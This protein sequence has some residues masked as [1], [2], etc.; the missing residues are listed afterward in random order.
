MEGMLRSRLQWFVCRTIQ[1]DDKI[2][3]KKEANKH[4]ILDVPVMCFYLQTCRLQAGHSEL[5]CR[6]R[7]KCWVK[8]SG[9][10]DQHSLTTK[11]KIQQE[12]PVTQW[13]ASERTKR[14]YH[15]EIKSGFSV[16]T[17]AACDLCCHVLSRKAENHR[18]TTAQC[19]TNADDIQQDNSSTIHRDI[20]KG[21]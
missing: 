14:I 21:S 16:S 5:H 19:L 18:A 1:S 20:K 9:C 4:V 2:S 3:S 13:N 11:G 8:F 12:L 7:G 10:V 15:C 17:A 6:R